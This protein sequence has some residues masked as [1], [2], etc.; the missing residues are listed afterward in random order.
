MD[1]QDEGQQKEYHSLMRRQ[2]INNITLCKNG[3][4]KCLDIFV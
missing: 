4:T 2:S 3:I 1:N